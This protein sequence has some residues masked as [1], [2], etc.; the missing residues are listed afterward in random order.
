MSI[1]LSHRSRRSRAQRGAVLASYK[2]P[3]GDVFERAVSAIVIRPAGLRAIAVE[4]ARHAIG[5]HEAETRFVRPFGKPL[6]RLETSSGVPPP[7]P[8]SH[9][10]RSGWP[11]PQPT[12]SSEM[13]ARLE[14][15][16]KHDRNF[17]KNERALREHHSL[18]V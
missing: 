2:S 13:S 10:E 3:G 16:L 11:V 14:L 17:G 15:Y 4:L 18:D 6:R 5:V 8:T 7:A 9:E 1:Q 12:A